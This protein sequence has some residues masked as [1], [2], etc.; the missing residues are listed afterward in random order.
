MSDLPEG[1]ARPAIGEV[2]T[3]SYGRGLPANERESGS[4]NVFGSNGVVGT[5]RTAITAAP[6]IVIGRKG[7]I[8]EIHY[9]DSPCYPIDTTYFV[10]QFNGLDPRFINN[11]FRSLPLPEMNRATAIPGLSRADVYSLDVP[12]PPLPEQRRIVAKLD[13]LTARAD[14]ARIPTLIARYKQRLLALA[15]SGELTAGWRETNP[16]TS[17][18]DHS[19]NGNDGRTD[20]LTAIPDSWMWTS[21]GNIARVTGGL[22]KN[23]SREAIKTRSPYL[24][25]ANVYANELRLNDVAD[26]GC[27]PSELAKTKLERGDLL[28]VEGNGSIEQVGRVAMWNDEIAD[29]SHQ[30]HIIRARPDDALV[31]GYG[32]FWLLSPIGR[33]A[34]ERVASSSSGLHTLSITKVNRFP[35]PVC[36]IKEQAEI[37]RCI[38]SAFGWL[39]RVAIDQ[40]AVARLLPKLDAAI[41]AKAFRGALVP[42]DPNDEPA[43]VLLERIK[44]ERATTA[45]KG[46]GRTAKPIESTGAA[47]GAATVRGAGYAKKSGDK[48]VSKSRD[49]VKGKP[50]LTNI[51]KTMNGAAKPEALFKKAD[52]DLVDFYRQLSDEHDRGWLV[53]DNHWVKAA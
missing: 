14:L 47:G 31:A 41:L 13:G 32:L 17:A 2:L 44:A 42:Q 18:F 21:F 43:S 5:H 15:F 52:L 53:D 22:T 8:G 36:S 23:A 19:P 28:I 11:L 7:S 26:I 27:T 12:L 6:V 35:I 50:Y 45:K 51:L 37:V 24:R 29:C 30:N 9:S 38:E 3:L 20:A 49:E 1:W 48:S 10:D 34:I 46:R 16:L 25:V 33:S 40:A 4:Y 39:D